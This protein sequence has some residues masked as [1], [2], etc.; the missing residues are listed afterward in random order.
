MPF[1][2]GHPDFLK[3]NYTLKKG[4]FTGESNPRWRLNPSYG[5]AHKWIFY[6][7]GKAKNCSNKQ[8]IY[9]RERT[10]SKGEI[11]KA[12]KRFEWAHKYHSYS[13]DPKD[14]IS[15]CASCHRKYD[16]G[17]LKLNLENEN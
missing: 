7:L 5:T 10:H 17:S 9:P 6:K 15:L 11:M 1:K 12:P 4:M 2:K 8:C 13:R 14:Y 16:Y 3:G